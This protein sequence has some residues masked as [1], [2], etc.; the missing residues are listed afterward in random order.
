MIRTTSSFSFF[1]TKVTKSWRKGKLPPCFEFHEYSD[2]KLLCVVACIH[3][4]VGRSAPW[5]TQAQ[6]Q[7][8]LEFQS[9]T[10]DNR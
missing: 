10:I 1:F 2:D 8:L 6:N 9:S 4:Y 5:R 3:E 7:L